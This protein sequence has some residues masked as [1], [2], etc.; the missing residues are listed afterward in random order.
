MY[1]IPPR[2]TPIT[3]IELSSAELNVSSVS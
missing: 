2:P 1:R 3:A